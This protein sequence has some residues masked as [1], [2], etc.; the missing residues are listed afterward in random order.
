V[1]RTRSV[2]VL[3]G[4][5]RRGSFSR[6]VAA[7]ATELSPPSLKLFVVELGQLPLCNQDDDERSPAASVAFRALVQPADALLFVTPEYNRSIPSPLKNALD[8]GSRPYG[9]SVWNAKPA[10]V[11]SS[12][13]GPIGGFGANQHLRQVLFALNVSAMPQPEA[14]IGGVDKL[15]DVT[16]QLVDQRTR[17]F[18]TSFMEAFAAWVQAHPQA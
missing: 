11:I 13:P 9:L 2:A 8:V 7:A 5:L 17:M 12:S 18:L 16:G 3:V 4:S 15:L 6:L 1:T 10:G 14:F